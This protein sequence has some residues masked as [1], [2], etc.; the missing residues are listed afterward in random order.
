MERRPVYVLQLTQLDPNYV[1]SKRI[2]YIDKEF[3]LI[4]EGAY[5]DKKGRLY[6]TIYARPQFEL[7]E[8]GQ[9]GWNLYYTVHDHIDYHTSVYFDLEFL[10]VYSRDDLLKR[11]TT[12]LK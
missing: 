7:P 3:F 6:R 12:G 2:F 5:Y 4:H 1:Y 11:L 9:F 8:L 10:A